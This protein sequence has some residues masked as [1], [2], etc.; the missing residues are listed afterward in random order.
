MGEIGLVQLAAEYAEQIA[1]YRAEFSPDRMQVSY[2]PDRIPGMDYLENFSDV[3]EWLRFCETEK[4]QI[5]WYMSVRKKDRRIVGFSCLR[6]S[7]EYDDDDPDFASHIGCSIRP[8]E[9]GKGYGKEQLRLVLNEA[10]TLGIARVRLVCRDINVGSIHVILA[11]GG[12]YI[13][14]IYGE[15]SGLTINRYDIDPA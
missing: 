5:T 1:A 6:H 8:S 3:R 10:R 14:S 4:G 2:D 9:Q 13:D 12:R 11:N 15:E 7:L